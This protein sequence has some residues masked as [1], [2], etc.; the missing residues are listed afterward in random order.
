MN[1][2][3]Y[4][5]IVIAKKKETMI[6]NIFNFP[7]CESKYLI[8]SV[9]FKKGVLNI[10]ASKLNF[11]YLDPKTIDLSNELKFFSYYY[12]TSLFSETKDYLNIEKNKK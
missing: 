4:L 5:R 2:K 9:Y 3:K 12:Y 1:Y 7:N 10:D 11:K 8:D 6:V